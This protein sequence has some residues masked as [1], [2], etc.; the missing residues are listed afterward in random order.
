MHLT[1]GPEGTSFYH[2]GDFAGTIY[3]DGAGGIELEAPIARLAA[4]Y[5]LAVM[6]GSS[7]ASI[8][9]ADRSRPR[10]RLEI[11]DLEDVHTATLPLADVG[12][13]LAKRYRSEQIDALERAS[14]AEL[15]ERAAGQL[16]AWVRDGSTAWH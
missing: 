15:L 1:V 7:T 9:A 10:D 13:L 12:A 11:P 14:H 2:N 8:A 6:E 5:L 4:A 3:F 16:T